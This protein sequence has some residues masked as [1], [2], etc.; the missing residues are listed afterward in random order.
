MKS[1]FVLS[2]L[3]LSLTTAAIAHQGA[4][5]IVKER[6]DSMGVIASGIKAIA[7]MMR[8]ATEIDPELI[9]TTMRD[10]VMRSSHLP[11]M[12]PEGSDDAPSEAGP[13]IWSDTEG[14]NAIFADLQMAAMDM[15]ELAAAGDTDGLNAAFGNVAATC[16]ACHA[17]YRVKRD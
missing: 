1:R 2:A 16:K 12:F 8:G 3:A 11:M 9:E 17:D 4:S 5:G 10:I 13:A 7:P 6:M 14:F 15:A